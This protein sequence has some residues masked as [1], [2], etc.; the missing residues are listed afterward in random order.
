MVVCTPE[1]ESF[2]LSGSE[3]F[4]SFT[5]TGGPSIRVDSLKSSATDAT[6]KR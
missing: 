1:D 3:I 5:P 2:E 4:L 6:G